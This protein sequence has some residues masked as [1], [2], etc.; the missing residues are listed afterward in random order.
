M[1]SSSWSILCDFR[2]L[3]QSTFQLY[4]YSHCLEND[5]ASFSMFNHRKTFFWCFF[6]RDLFCA[7][8]ESKN[9]IFFIFISIFSISLQNWLSKN[10]VWQTKH[11]I[12]IFFL[13]RQ[14]DVF[15]DVIYSARKKNL[16]MKCFSFQSF[17]SRCKI[18]TRKILC[19][20]D[21]W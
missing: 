15:F 16:A 8:K 1:F 12:E 3:V 18:H 20:R 7:K 5:K 13:L 14:N 10:S 11:M 6:R 4:L 9:K 2:L 19:K 17:Q 21:T